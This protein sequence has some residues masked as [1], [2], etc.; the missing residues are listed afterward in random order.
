MKKKQTIF[1]IAVVTMIIGSISVAQAKPGTFSSRTSQGYAGYQAQLGK[2]FKKPNISMQK[3]VQRVVRLLKR[4]P[5]SSQVKFIMAQRLLQLVNIPSWMKQRII[6]QL[7]RE[8]G[9]A[10]PMWSRLSRV[11]LKNPR[12]RTVQVQVRIGN[13]SI[14][15][16]NPSYGT[17]YIRSGESYS[18]TTG[19]QFV[20]YRVT[21]IEHVTR[22]VIRRWSKVKTT[23]PTIHSTIL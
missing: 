21:G 4:A 14:C 9:I 10:R 23:Q 17:K 13:S 5:F 16:L 20:C 6:M 1:G 12:R 7:R 19:N 11:N 22:P 3:K 18:V 2:L 8:F 15:S